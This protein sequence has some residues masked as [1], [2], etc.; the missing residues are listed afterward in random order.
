MYT[1]NEIYRIPFFQTLDSNDT[2]DNVID[3]LTKTISRKYILKY[4]E[5]LIEEDVPF[6]LG[7]V[8]LD[9]F[10][11][12]NDNYGHTIGDLTLIKFSEALVS[13]VSDM[14]LVGRFG[15]D[16]FIV[17]FLGKTDYKSVYE[18]YNQMY[19]YSNVVRLN[20]PIKHNVN[21]VLT[22]TTGAASYP[23]DSD[24][25][26]DL[27]LKA[28][29][30][31]YR[32]KTKGRN[33][34]IVYVDYKHKDIDVTKSVKRSL[35]LSLQEIFSVFESDIPLTNKINQALIDA[36][37]SL[38]ITDAFYL[39]NNFNILNGTSMSTSMVD[40]SDFNADTLLEEDMIY[41]CNNPRD[42]AR[43]SQK[44]LEF[45]NEI[46]ILSILICKIKVYG[47]DFGYIVLGESRIERIW[48]EDDLTLAV[49]L[50]KLVGMY[51]MNK[52]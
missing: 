9:N 23:N 36:K 42:I 7:I 43:A 39:D 33:C 8:D 6:S 26:E 4:V 45:C 21:V 25:F 10:K 38:K 13:Y 17:V 48:Q 51:N 22:A 30:A 18:F 5:H 15:G 3:P 49:Y 41:T 40:L 24:N 35:H 14:G 19:N 29:K 31:L 20:Y 27:F 2:Y 16:E 44:L 47:K 32:G 12:V 46:K 52:E 11:Y 28:D 50:S 1:K 37:E 34:F